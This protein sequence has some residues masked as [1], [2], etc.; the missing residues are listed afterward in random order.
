M[1]QDFDGFRG[2]G[3]GRGFSGG[4]RGRGGGF[5]GGS[6]GF[7]GGDRGGSRGFRGGD[8][9]GS[10]GGSR[11]FGGGRGMDRGGFRGGDRGGFRGGR[12][13]DRGSFRGGD[14]GGFRGDRGGFRGA[15]RGNFRGG[16]TRGKGAENAPVYREIQDGLQLWV[17]YKTTPSFDE[18]KE[19][20]PGFHSRH[21]RPTGVFAANGANGTSNSVAHILLFTSVESLEAAKAKLSEDDNVESVDYMGL[22]SAKKQP[23][24]IEN[25]QL[26]LKFDGVKEEQ[27]IKDMDE[28]IVS[29]EF[30]K[31]P[32]NC[33]VELKSLEDAQNILPVLQGKV[34]E[35]GLLH[36]RESFGMKYQAAALAGIH[37]NL[38]VLRDVP[39]N[40]TIK[41]IAEIFPDINSFTLYNKTFHESQY[42][43]ASM[44]FTSPKRVDEILNDGKVIEI[45]GKKVYPIPAHSSL[46]EELQKLGKGQKDET[47]KAAA[48]LVK[49][50]S[51]PPSKKIKMEKSENDEDGDEVDGEEEEDDEEGEEEDE[52]EEGE[53]EDEEGENEEDD[54]EEEDDDDAE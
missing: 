31:E 37:R 3:R 42:C 19:Q 39:K 21:T 24:C 20:H 44:R 12:G 33:L 22:R 46:L 1:G 14:R 2:R 8:R 45:A 41:E 6:R 7:R 50:A 11:G 9:G 4:D 25:R 40:I 35:N 51:E 10:R 43:H 30:M 32:S 5:R 27:T 36:V 18:T 54:D 13:G 17:Q 34:G 53:D 26:Y 52:D 28:R 29:V 38:L 49:E 48:E 15:P 47:L 16:S 23:N